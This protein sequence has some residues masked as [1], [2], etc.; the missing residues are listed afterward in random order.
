MAIPPLPALGPSR[1]MTAL[2]SGSIRTAR[3][4]SVT[5]TQTASADAAMSPPDIGPDET[6]IVAVTVLVAGSTRDTVAAVASMTHTASG[7]S[8]RKL[9]L[10]PT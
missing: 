4:S 6:V 7:P 2:E 3:A 8:A 5:R 9:A 1:W 10:R